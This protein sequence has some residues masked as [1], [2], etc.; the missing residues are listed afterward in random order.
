MDWFVYDRDLRH[1]RLTCCVFNWLKNSTFI[2]I[3]NFY[4]SFATLLPHIK[5]GPL[6]RGQPHLPVVNHYVHSI[7]D[8]NFTRSF[9]TKLVQ[10]LVGFQLVTSLFWSEVVVRRCSVKKSVLR[11][12]AKFTGKH[13]CQSL[14]LIKLQ[15]S[16]YFSFKVSHY[17]I[18]II[19]HKKQN[20]FASISYNNAVLHLNNL[21]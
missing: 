5:F 11:N 19:L 10:H 12:F 17:T 8:P 21:S 6:S 7:F 3:F 2:E 14:F 20:Y 4:F 18:L 1:K 16:G 9:V 15:A 13:L